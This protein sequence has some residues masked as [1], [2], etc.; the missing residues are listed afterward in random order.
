MAIHFESCKVSLSDYFYTYMYIDTYTNFVF[1]TDSRVHFDVLFA[2]HRKSQ[3]TLY[4]RNT[5]AH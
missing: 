3:F 5:Y 1:W 4:T 2:L